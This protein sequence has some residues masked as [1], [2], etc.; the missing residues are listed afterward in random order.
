MQEQEKDNFY[1]NISKWINF[2]IKDITFQNKSKN[3]IQVYARQLEI[4]KD[5]CYHNS[6]NMSLQDVNKPFIINA[7]E[8]RGNRVSNSTKCLYLSVLK[9]FFCFIET[10]ESNNGKAYDFSGI[11]ARISINQHSKIPEYLDMDERFKL[12]NYLEHLKDKKKTYI[13]YRNILLCKLL[14]HT[15]IRISEALSIKFDDFHQISAQDT[16]TSISGGGMRLLFF[17]L[18]NYI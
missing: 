18:T 9:S 2:Y 14:L 6:K 15:G 13:L 8:N 12:I 16:P 17:S 5:Y 3:T 11:F 7:I 4:F 10:E 1:N